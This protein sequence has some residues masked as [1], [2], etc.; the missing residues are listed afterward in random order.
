MSYESYPTPPPESPYG[1]GTA[2][3]GDPTVGPLRGATIQ[4]AVRRFFQRYALFRGRASRSEFWWWILA[5]AIIGTVISVLIA[6]ASIFRVV[7]VL[8]DLAVLVPSLALG[9]RRL[10]DTNR[11]GWWQ[12]LAFIPIVGWIILVVWFASEEKAEGVRFD[13]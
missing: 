1:Y 7:E 13:A 9:A 2:A 12:L 6:I 5:N 10:H 4:Q 8:W 3:P 11:S